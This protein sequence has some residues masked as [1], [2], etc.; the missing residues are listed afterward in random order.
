MEPPK[1]T[2]EPAHSATAANDAD[3]W[4]LYCDLQNLCVQKGLLIAVPRPPHTDPKDGLQKPGSTHI[5]E[6]HQEE[7]KDEGKDRKEDID[8]E[9]IIYTSPLATGSRSKNM[10][11]GARNEAN[12]IMDAWMNLGALL[13]IQHEIGHEKAAMPGTVTN[14]GKMSIGIFED[15]NR[16]MNLSAG[17]P[18]LFSKKIFFR[19]TPQGTYRLSK[20]SWRQRCL[21]THLS[22]SGK[23]T[24]M[25][26][27]SRDREHRTD[28]SE[29]NRCVCS[30]FGLL[31]HTR[32]RE[33]ECPPGKTRQIK[34]NGETPGTPQGPSPKRGKK[35]ENNQKRGAGQHGRD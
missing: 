8:P 21:T 31:V 19:T 3:L 30:A 24:L 6:G 9:K 1:Y 18:I 17:R 7:F 12:S 13:G 35:R 16:P 23:C 25:Q 34:K 33:S 28:L 32:P 4:A 14:S 2:E 15:T 20:D 10:P 26:R 29:K 22:G 27:R 5:A 11:N